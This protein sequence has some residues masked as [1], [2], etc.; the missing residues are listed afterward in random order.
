MRIKKVVDSRT[1]EGRNLLAATEH[2]KG[3]DIFDVYEKCSSSKVI[4]FE[5]VY[6]KYCLDHSAH[7]FHVCSANSFQFCVAWN[8]I[9]ENGQHYTRYITAKYDYWIF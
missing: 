1:A 5:E 2:F 7:D 8:A 6:R 9:S 3:Y 4:A